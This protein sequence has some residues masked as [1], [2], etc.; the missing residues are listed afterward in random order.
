[1]AADGENSSGSVACLGLIMSLLLLW[2]EVV[3]MWCGVCGVLDM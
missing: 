2:A 3:V 1:M